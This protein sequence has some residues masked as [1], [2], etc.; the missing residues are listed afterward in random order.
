MDVEKT[1]SNSTDD[2]SPRNSTQGRPSVQIYHDQDISLNLHNKKKKNYVNPSMILTPMKTMMVKI[3]PI[4]RK[5][6]SLRTNKR[7]IQL[8]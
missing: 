1:L 2:D 8:P 4:K 5:C 7:S 3:K 6:E